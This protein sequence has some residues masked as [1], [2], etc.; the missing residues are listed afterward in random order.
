MGNGH[1]NYILI[2]VLFVIEAGGFVKVG[3]IRRVHSRALAV[4]VGGVSH[5]SDDSMSSYIPRNDH[6]R[7]HKDMKV[8]LVATFGLIGLSS[9]ANA[10][11]NPFG[12]WDRKFATQPPAGRPL[13][14]PLVYGVEKV[15]PPSLLPRSQRAYDSTA[16]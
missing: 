3:Y 15:D 7:I 13:P 14:R 8:G 5:A 12:S 9:A 2:L 10:E 11:T 6:S 1:I 16:R 4:E